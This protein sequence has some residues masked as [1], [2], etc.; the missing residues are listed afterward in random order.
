MNT[1]YWLD[2]HNE[3]HYPA[4]DHDLH[5]HTLI[6]GGGLTGL[7]T[8]YECS[9]HTKQIVVVEADQVGFG[10]SGR[11]TGKVT[12]QHG[13]IYHKIIKTH[14]QEAAVA[15]Y[16]AQKE[17]INTIETI[18]DSHGIEC[19]KENKSASIYGNSD[20]GIR[21]IQAEYEAYQLLGIPCE[22]QENVKSPIVMKAAL[23]VENQ[24]GYDP[25]AYLLGLSDILDQSGIAIYEHSR[26]DD[27]VRV[28]SSWRVT[29]NDHHVFAQNIVSAT[30]TPLLD[31]FTFFYA[32]T[33][34]SISHLALLDC[35]RMMQDIMLYGLDDPMTSYHPLHDSKLLCGGYEHNAAQANASDFNA[36]LNSL[37]KEWNVEKPLY[38][39]DTQDLISH[40]YLPLIGALAPRYPDFYI[41][42][43]FSKWGNTQSHVAAKVIADAIAQRESRYSALFSPSRIEPLLQGKA[44]RMNAKTVMHF[45]TSQFPKLQ[46]YEL[47]QGK[48]KRIELDQRLYG[49]YCDEND[50]VYIVDIRCPHMGCICDFN[51]VDHTWDCPCHGSRFAYDGAIIKGPAQSALHSRQQKI[52]NQI[53]PREWVTHKDSPTS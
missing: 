19:Q 26:A 47:E 41:A 10:S 31:A 30:M 16:Q 12:F 44:L 13:A 3:K 32:K 28:G 21:Q 18:I 52:P 6:I 25:Y 38:V 9:A 50:D 42:C 39:W 49:M 11:N 14:S 7:A 22:Y 20:K 5:I 53:D 34:P 17:A 4:L 35:D 24:M 46:D 37:C 2:R 29:I 27:I 48:G 8:A 33:Y 40:D 1:S 51:E 43:G 15:Y 23:Q 36:W 45:L